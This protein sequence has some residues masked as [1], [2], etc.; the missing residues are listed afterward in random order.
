ML[1]RINSV[2]YNIQ[3]LDER[4]PLKRKNK[5]FEK[6]I[7]KVEKKCLTKSFE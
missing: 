7:K 4:A 3:A 2:R 6:Q 1:D 5:A